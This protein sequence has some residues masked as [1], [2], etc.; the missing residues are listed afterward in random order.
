MYYSF[1]CPDCHQEI[2]IEVDDRIL[3]WGEECENCKREFNGDE[4]DTIYSNAMEDCEA[5]KIDY[6]MDVL[7]NR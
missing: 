5:Q 3:Y 4:I 1:D 6:A 2:V 7:N